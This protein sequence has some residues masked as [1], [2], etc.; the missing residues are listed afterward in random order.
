VNVVIAII[1]GILGLL[2]GSF[3]NVLIYRIPKQESIVFPGSHCM[4]CGRNLRWFELIPVFS[5]IF[6]RGRCKGCKVRIS[7]RYALVELLTAVLFVLTFLVYGLHPVLP[8]YLA[9][10]AVLIAVFFIDLDHM[11]IPNG[12]VIAGIVLAAGV[13]VLNIFLSVPIYEYGA[14]WTPF[15]GLLPGSVALFLIGSIASLIYT[16]ANKRA[17]KKKTPVKDAESEVESVEAIGFGDIKILIPIGLI[18]GWKYCLFAM[19]IAVITA[20]LTGVIL[21]TA[22]IRK[23]RDEIPFGPFIVLG[24]I[25][26]LLFGQPILSAYL[27]L[28]I[29]G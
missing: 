2:I 27:N 19:L 21:L 8:M 10:I 23:R 24:T 4:S 16:L 22:K 6:L 15:L 26:A 3:L 5:W 9:F 7:P 11:I 14:W 25:I 1:I 18:L 12:L 28:F 17:A 29:T 13:F 20:G